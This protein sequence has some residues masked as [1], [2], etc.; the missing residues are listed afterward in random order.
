MGRLM[1]ISE[2]FMRVYSPRRPP[3]RP[4][5]LGVRCPPP[6][7]A[8]C[9]R[10]A[11]LAAV[12]RLHFRAGLEPELAFGDDRLPG[13]ETLFDDDVFADALA[14]RDRLLGDGV[15]RFDEEH[16]LSVLAGLHRLARE[17]ERVR[18][19][20][21]A[22]ADARELARPQA[23]IVVCEP[24]LQLDRVGGRVDGVVDEVQLALDRRPSSASCGVAV[25]GILSLRPMFCLIAG[26]AAR[27][28]TENVT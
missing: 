12:A 7:A 26:E 14:D 25:T 15:V 27:T 28:G 8:A 20:R 11:A 23:V 6:S 2:M 10:R 17:H 24:R 22:Q 1:K 19:G 5:R 18:N 16:E 9:C 4:C 3:C 13:L 21:D